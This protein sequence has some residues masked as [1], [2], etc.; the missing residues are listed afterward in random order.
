MLT[1]HLPVQVKKAG[2]LDASSVEDEKELESVRKI[3]KPL[4][5]AVG[6]IIFLGFIVWPCLTLPAKIFRW[7]SSLTHKAV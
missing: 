1:G 4:W 6:I 2:A 3:R 5:I 7:E